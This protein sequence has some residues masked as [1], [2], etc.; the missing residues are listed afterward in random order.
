MPNLFSLCYHS[1]ARRPRLGVLRKD[2][3]ITYLH[4]TGSGT[5]GFR[6]Y[7]HGHVE[8]RR[9]H[10]CLRDDSLVRFRRCQSVTDAEQPLS[11]CKSGTAD[12]ARPDAD[13]PNDEDDDTRNGESRWHW[14]KG[15]GGFELQPHL[16]PACG[17][18]ESCEHDAGR[19]HSPEIPSESKIHIL[20]EHE[21][22]FRLIDSR[23]PSL[24]ITYA[25]A[26]N[27]DS[28]VDFL[29]QE[30]GRAGLSVK[31]DRW[32]LSG[33]RR[34]WD[35]IAD[36][37]TN[38]TQSDGWAIYATQ[39]SLGS[40]PCRE[41]LA[42]GLKRALESRNESYPVIALF[43]GPVDITILPASLSTRLCVSTTDPDWKER[44]VAAVE[45]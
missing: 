27:R 36:F 32:N 40:E 26:D 38:S 35:Q 11:V 5:L 19:F 4:P 29:A 37:I 21:W 3:N 31:L 34:L 42:Y 39:N 22:I 43:P 41:E 14:L 25:W 44:I 17:S 18:R 1:G 9:G 7:R 16:I 12:P 20:F 6:I 15:L 24:W 2:V 45:R 10:P 28:D 33:G 30:L 8:A 23:M 13:A